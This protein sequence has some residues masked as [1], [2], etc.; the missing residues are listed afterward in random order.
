[1]AEWATV[2][3]ILAMLIIMIYWV[4]YCR[5]KRL[6]R[7]AERTRDI[8]PSRNIKKA[9]KL[10][11]EIYHLAQRE[12]AT[13]NS[14]A[15]YQAIDLLKEL[16]GKEI[17]ADG[18]YRKLTALLVGAVRSGQPEIAAAALDAYRQLFRCLPQSEMPAAIEQLA[19]ISAVS[20]KEKHNFLAGKSADI[21]FLLL[22]KDSGINGE[23]IKKASVRALKMIGSLALR[24]RDNGLFKEMTV[25]LKGLGDSLLDCP[26]EVVAMTGEWLHRIIRL[27]DESMFQLLA[28][29]VSS[30]AADKNLGGRITP[31]LIKEWQNLSSTACLNPNGLLAVR[32]AELCLRLAINKMDMTQWN[33]AVA[34]AASVAR[35]AAQRQGIAPALPLILPLFEMGR[36]L[37]GLELKFGQPEDEDSYRQKALYVVVRECL[38]LVEF[39]AKQDVST[40]VVDVIAE[41]CKMWIN[42]GVPSPKSCKRF[43]QLLLAY[44]TRTRGRLARKI[45]LSEDGVMAPS[46]L[47]DDELGRLGFLS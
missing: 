42:N 12:I 7:L 5:A 32:I 39:L 14:A 43:C 35:I 40:T 30:F 44:W 6:D 3:A 45:S 33:E 38:G 26:D 46:L 31:G 11:A 1:M 22:E 23:L 36:E 20:V 19:F 4:R 21:I 41:L 25:R 13:K 9:A 18:D 37:L 47:T 2:I 16:F 28:D 8:K 17:V 15:A 34:G 27:D 10:L 29:L 24:R